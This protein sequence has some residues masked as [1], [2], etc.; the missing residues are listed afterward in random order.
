MSHLAPEVRSPRCKC[1]VI[2][3]SAAV[4]RAGGS[5][6]VSSKHKSPLNT[7][8]TGKMLRSCFLKMPFPWRLKNQDGGSRQ[9]RTWRRCAQ[10]AV[11]VPPRQ[12][13][14]GEALCLHKA[15][16]AAKGVF[17]PFSPL[18]TDKSTSSI[19]RSAAA[20]SIPQEADCL[21]PPRRGPNPPGWMLIRHSTATWKGV[22]TWTMTDRLSITAQSG[23]WAKLLSFSLCFFIFKDAP[24][25]SPILI[26]KHMNTVKEEP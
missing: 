18:S 14:K 7:L 11:F 10:T 9:F 19:T 3:A 22:R 12:K 5:K 2:H 15:D 20:A 6:S 25:K 26:F 23:R 21:P 17:A 4:I 13:V 24:D 16:R 8:H 1:S